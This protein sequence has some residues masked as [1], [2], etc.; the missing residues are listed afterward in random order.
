MSGLAK[1]L[2]EMGKT[3]AGSDMSDSEDISELRKMGIDVNIGHDRDNIIGRGWEVLIVSQAVDDNNPEILA[4]KEIGLPI[5]RRSQLIG[6]LMEDKVGIAVSGMHGKSTV[7]AMLSTILEGAGEDPTILVGARVK[8]IDSNARYGQSDLVVA[9]ACE[10]KRSFLDFEPTIIVLTNIEEEHMD[11][12]KDLQDILDT[13]KMFIN[14]L[15]NDGL[16][17][18]CLDDKNVCDLIK[19]SKAN[20]VGYGFEKCPKWFKGSYW[21]VVQY[22]EKQAKNKFKIEYNG[23]LLQ[24]DWELIVPG[25]FN[26]LNAVA[27]VIVADFLFVDLKKVRDILAGFNGAGRRFDILGERDGIVVIDDYG[28]HPTEIKNL[29][30]GAGGFYKNKKIWVVFQSHQYSRTWQFLEDFGKC[31]LGADKVIV[32][33]IYEA[34]D[35]DEDKKK[36]NGIDLVQEMKKNG[37]KAEYIDNFND[38]NCN[39]IKN[40]GKFDVLI[41]V[42]AGDVNKVGKLFLSKKK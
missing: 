41:T 9:E 25:K 32:T 19:K 4:A 14:K 13:Y 30:I 24:D 31:F 29:M 1:V 21:Q 34:R 37:L 28:H 40:I 8:T 10:Y 26:V 16:L 39:L 20:I 38:I 3:V 7:S 17:V 2:K 18:A 27:S 23:E 42:G 36:V 33:K 12:Y 22:R 11:V 15:P 35:S 6:R 5:W